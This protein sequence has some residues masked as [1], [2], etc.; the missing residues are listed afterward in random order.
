H[1]YLQEILETDIK[2]VLKDWRRQQ[3]EEDETAPYARIH[4]LKRQYFEF[5]SAFE[6]RKEPAAR[7]RLQ[8][9]FSRALLGA[10]GYET[11]PSVQPVDDGGLLPIL[12]DI[13]KANG[14]PELWIMDVI[15]VASDVTDPLEL[16][17]HTSQFPDD[18]EPDPAYLQMSL[19]EL[20]SKHVF[21]RS[22]PPR[23]IIVVSDAQIALLDRSKWNEKRLLRF[24]LQEILGRRER[25]T[26]QAM[27]AL[28]HRDNVSP[29]DGLSLLDTLDENSHK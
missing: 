24:D 1:H 3:N 13:T 21:G 4:K 26:L 16:P 14:S 15:D 7:L 9:R 6:D 23:W 5:R 27:A 17:L 8:R 11:K 20:I 12:G 18:V 28:L 25:S 29:E 19:T 10:L 2:D 22:E